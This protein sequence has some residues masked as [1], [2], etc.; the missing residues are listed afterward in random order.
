MGEIVVSGHKGCARSRSRTCKSIPI[1]LLRQETRNV[2]LKA[3][4]T[5]NMCF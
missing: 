5:G 1:L 2:L 3:E 4:L